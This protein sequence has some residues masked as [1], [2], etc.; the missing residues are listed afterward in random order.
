MHGGISGKNGSAP[1]CR[2]SYLLESATYDH[3][4]AAV[5]GCHIWGLCIRERVVFLFCFVFLF[6]LLLPK[7]I[8]SQLNSLYVGEK[9]A[10]P[11][12]SSY[13]FFLSHSLHISAQS[14]THHRLVQLILKRKKILIIP[15]YCFN[16]RT[17]ILPP[18]HNNSLLRFLHTD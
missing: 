13:F 16:N 6:S 7:I 15:Y 2:F 11:L 4:A 17:K 1:A 14:M 5:S 18:S 12:N 8:M 9:N 10:I 3:T